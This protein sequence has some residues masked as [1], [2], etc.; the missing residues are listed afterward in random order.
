MTNAFRRRRA[1]VLWPCLA[2]SV[3][4]VGGCRVDPGLPDYRSHV[5][6]RGSEVDDTPLPGEQPFVENEPRLSLGIF[7]E[8]GAT[9]EILINDVDTHYYIFENSFSLERSTERVEGAYSDQLTLKGGTFYGGGVIYDQPRDLSRWT[10]LHIAL[11][12]ADESFADVPLVFLSGPR[13]EAAESSVPA[14]DYG[15]LNDG[16]WHHLAIP[17]VD[18]TGFDP[19][20]VVSPLTLSAPVNEAGHRLWIDD[21]Y[22][23]QE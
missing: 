12:S 7:Y 5:G 1:P 18:V 6:V 9:D 11:R 23:T 8:G 2:L 4:F 14:S 13:A 3:G 19:S 21:V 22:Y 10:T 15:Y 16:A 17:L 20:Q